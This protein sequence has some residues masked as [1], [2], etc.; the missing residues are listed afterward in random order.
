MATGSSRPARSC[1]SRACRLPRGPTGRRTPQPL[2][3]P[4]L[5]PPHC[6]LRN[7]WCCDDRLNPSSTPRS[8]SARLLEDLAASVGSV[9]DAYDNALAESTIWL[10][11][12]ECIR[13][14]N[15]FLDGPLKQLADV[16]KA[17]MDRVPLVQHRP[18]PQ[19]PGHG[20]ARRVRAYLLRSNRRLIRRRGHP[21]EGGLK[22]GTVH[23]DGVVGL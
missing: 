3:H 6:H 20:P 14:A 9:G 2:C 21:Q 22:P 11:Q 8:G 1:V 15:P 16:E 4:T 7:R 17:T 19:H 13:K 23:S 18:S 5:W 10:F 12:N